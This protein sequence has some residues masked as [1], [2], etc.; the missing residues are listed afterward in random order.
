MNASFEIQLPQDQSIDT[1]SCNLLLEVSPEYLLTCIIN[2]TD[3]KFTALEH[4]RL[5]SHDPLGS[6]KMVLFNNRWISKSYNSV[7]IV[8]NF[9]DGLIIPGSL[10]NEEADKD[11]LDIIFGDLNEAKPASEYLASWDVHNIYRVPD[12]YT[13]LL[14]TQFVNPRSVHIYSVILKKLAQEKDDLI[15]D[16]L[17]VIFFERKLFVAFVKNKSLMLIQTFDYETA[18]DVNYSLLNICTRFDISCETVDIRI[19]GLL[20]D[21]SSVYNEIRKYFLNVRLEN[22]PDNLQYAEGFDEFPQHFFNSV[23]W[24][25]LCE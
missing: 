17:F 4:F 16:H 12:A 18:E 21:Q 5:D 24:S 11:S 22:R 8:Y 23:Y 1:S 6:F 9:P 10:Q 19:S 3:K 2:D 25:A 7:K 15:N 20:D 14:N 13:T